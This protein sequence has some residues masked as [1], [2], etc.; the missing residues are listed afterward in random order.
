[1]KAWGVRDLDVWRGARSET[2]VQEEVDAWKSGGGWENE[3]VRERRI[4]RCFGL[5]C[6]FLSCRAR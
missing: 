4:G 3:N 2:G 1:M 6:F 5:T